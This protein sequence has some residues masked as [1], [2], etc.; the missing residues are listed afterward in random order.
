MTIDPDTVFYTPK[1]NPGAMTQIGRLVAEGRQSDARLILEMI[2]IPQAVWFTGGS[3]QEVWRTVATVA[4]DAAAKK[5]TPIMV[6]YNLPFRDCSQFSAGGAASPAAY[7]EWITAFAA[8]IGEAPAVVIL[9]PDALGIIPWYRPFRGSAAEQETEWCRPAEADAGTASGE[10]FAMLSAAVDALKA[11]PNARVYLDGAHSAWLAPGDAAHRLI[12]A[13]VA[14]ADG[15]FLNVSNF[16][17]TEELVR[18]GRRVSALIALALHGGATVERL[19][20]A[21]HLPEPAG[22][23]A[24]DAIEAALELEFAAAGLALEPA[25]QPHFVIDT[26]RNGQGPWTPTGSHPDPQAWCNPPGRGA[27]RRPTADTGEPLLDACLWIKVPGESDGACTRGMGDA[28]SAVDPEWQQ[29]DPPAGQWFPAMALAL[30][31][32]ALPPLRP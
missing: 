11:R 15:F 17:R 31:S 2:A 14:R 23:D 12:Q 16:R 25:A 30:A 6:P 10:R 21:A 27:G 26:S 4:Q 7:L 1:P 13:G 8:G 19:A 18:Y 22:A 32:G 9:E 24:W 3:P 20:A 29:V 28:G 5:A